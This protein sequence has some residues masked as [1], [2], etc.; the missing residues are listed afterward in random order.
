[1]K[2]KNINEILGSDTGTMETL[3]MLTDNYKV[4]PVLRLSRLTPNINV[5][6]I[7]N[8]KQEN[9]SAYN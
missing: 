9:H 6:F 1:M 4:Q 8:T 2:K 7:Y 5:F 3:K